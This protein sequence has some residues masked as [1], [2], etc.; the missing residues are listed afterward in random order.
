[1]WLSFRSRYIPSTTDPVDVLFF[2]R[3]SFVDLFCTINNVWFCCRCLSHNVNKGN[4]HCTWHKDTNHDECAISPICF[5]GWTTA[6]RRCFSFK[7]PVRSEDTRR[8]S[9]KYTNALFLCRCVS[10]AE[11]PTY[12]CYIKCL[13]FK[14]IQVRGRQITNTPTV[15]SLL[16]HQSKCIYQ[17]KLFLALICLTKQWVY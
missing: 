14:S 5:W 17:L 10:D 13:S 1:M 7:S 2:D 15:C 16:P 3:I 8:F 12:C 4:S 9:T 11:I 6:I